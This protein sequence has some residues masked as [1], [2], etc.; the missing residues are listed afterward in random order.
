MCFDS[1]EE[2]LSVPCG[3]SM[4]AHYQNACTVFL[5]I[6]FHL[7][8]GHLWERDLRLLVGVSF[9]LRS[10]EYAGPRTSQ[11]ELIPSDGHT[12]T[13][14]DS[15]SPMARGGVPGVIIGSFDPRL[16]PVNGFD[17]PFGSTSA[18]AFSTRRTEVI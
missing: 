8:N 18:G 14:S 7:R 5:A 11:E 3:H 1:R 2:M 12:T 9:G 6:L 16:A 4:C 17:L 15:H 10:D 13:V